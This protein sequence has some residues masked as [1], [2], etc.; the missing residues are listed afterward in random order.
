MS[1][2]TVRRAAR[3]LAGPHDPSAMAPF[4]LLLSSGLSANSGTAR[5]KL[6]TEI[7]K[8]IVSSVHVFAGCTMNCRRPLSRPLVPT[9]GRMLTISVSLKR[10]I[11]MQQIRQINLNR[12]PLSMDTQIAYRSN[13]NM[14]ADEAGAGVELPLSNWK[15]T[16][17][18]S[19][20]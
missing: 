19:D 17:G 9:H 10:T 6:V 14:N 16:L 4:A 7:I 1:F 5:C 8:Q 2:C 13:L 15:Y 20:T 11:S 18:F 12:F 3:A